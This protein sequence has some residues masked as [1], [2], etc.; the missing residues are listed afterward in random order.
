MDEH[1]TN[2]PGRDEDVFRQL[3]A[4]LQAG[5]LIGPESLAQAEALLDGVEDRCA[6]WHFLKGA[7]CYRKGWMDEARRHY[8]A[9]R[10]M[11]PENPEYQ[12][13]VERMEAGGRSDGK[14]GTLS[15]DSACLAAGCA[16]K[17]ISCGY[18]CYGCADLCVLGC[19]F[20]GCWHCME[21]CPD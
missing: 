10:T 6:E 15:A 3:R 21:D 1:M 12:K 14:R 19:F 5:N 20:W 17:A 9:A 2:T 7:I 4:D 13:T 16:L 18:A 8:E 11:E